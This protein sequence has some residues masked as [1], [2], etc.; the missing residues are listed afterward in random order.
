MLEMLKKESNY[1]FTENGALTYKSTLSHCLDLFATIGALRNANEERIIDIFQKAYAEDSDLAMKILFFARDIRGGLGERKVFRIIFNWLAKNHKASVFKNLS[2]VAEFGRYD[3]LMVL[4]SSPCQTAMLDYIKEQLHKDLEAARAN[5]LQNISLLAKWLPSVNTSNEASV[6]QAKIIARR[7]NM[8]ERDYRKTLSY[9]REKINIIEN[10]LRTKDY[11]FDYSKQPSG[12]MLK[13]RQAFWRNDEE[14][15]STFLESVA[16]GE[17]KINTGAIT[18][19]QIV[20]PLINTYQSE[21]SKKSLDIA[22]NALEDFTNAE[23]SLVVVDGSGSMYSGQPYAISIALSLGI[24]FAERNKG[25]FKNHFITFSENPQLVEIK[26]KDIAEKV[27]YCEAFNEV[28]NTNIQRVF[29][30][31]LYT[32]LNNNVPQEELPS[33][34][35]FITDMEFDSCTKAGN[36]TNFE[37]AKI[38]FEQYG[39][40]LPK[41]VFWNVQSRTNQQPVRMHDSGA[42]LVSGY[43]PRI[44]GMLTSNCLDPYTF[45]ME[46]INQERYANIVA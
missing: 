7:L 18:P 3:D 37:R 32:A 21:E 12:A 24:Y 45:M 15:Y 28:A 29:E 8:Q 44:F 16:K 4:L 36:H 19:H 9:L 23:N 13:Y 46:S 33:T 11:S 10:N 22:W 17:S 34:L 1:T 25:K 5:D 39:Y 30:L 20:E 26:G 14:R 31:I 2:N 27:R 38:L 42:I 41:V 6:K 43:S 35:Y 40:K